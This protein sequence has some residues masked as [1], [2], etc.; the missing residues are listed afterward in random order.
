MEAGLV[1]SIPSTRIFLGK[2]IR[3]AAGAVKSFANSTT[4][5]I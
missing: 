1:F 3:K 2:L 5:K 4:G